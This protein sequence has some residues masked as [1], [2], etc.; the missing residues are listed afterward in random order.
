MGGLVQEEKAYKMSGRITRK[1]V[2]TEETPPVVKYKG[3]GC[4]F[5]YSEMGDI[6]GNRV[7]T[8]L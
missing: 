3:G 7:K 2:I 1:H 8:R 6:G 5:A 4:S